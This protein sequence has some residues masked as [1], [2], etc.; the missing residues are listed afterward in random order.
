MNYRVMLLYYR[1]Y[2][3]CKFI[4][5]IY[6]CLPIYTCWFKLTVLVQNNNVTYYPSQLYIFTSFYSLTH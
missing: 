5:F 6:N 4:S 2:Y 1:D 3:V